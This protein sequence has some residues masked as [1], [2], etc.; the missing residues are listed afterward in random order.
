ME[1][2]KDK[3]HELNN[4]LFK[5]ENESFKTKS[6]LETKI[7]E[8]THSNE[9][10]VQ[11]SQKEKRFTLQIE[12]SLKEKEDSLVMKEKNIQ[13]E[14]LELLQKIEDLAESDIKSRKHIESLRVDITNTKEEN[15]QMKNDKRSMD[16]EFDKLKTNRNEEG[17]KFREE[18]D[19]RESII[20]NNSEQFLLIVKENESNLTKYQMISAQVEEVRHIIY[21]YIY[22]IYLQ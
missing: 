10:L 11:N 14:K 18:I 6:D 20:K 7:T 16:E 15:Y 21:I 1:I 8:L 12:K 19:K 2:E 22:I 5:L 3:S 4:Q 17:I 9:I 13:D